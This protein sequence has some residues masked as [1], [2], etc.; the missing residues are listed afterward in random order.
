MR[1]KNRSPERPARITSAKFFQNR[2]A[3][4]LALDLRHRFRGLPN[5]RRSHRHGWRR[6]R[7][8]TSKREFLAIQPAQHPSVGALHRESQRVADGLDRRHYAMHARSAVH[9]FV[10]RLRNGFLCLGLLRRL[11]LSRRRN[12]VPKFAHD[13]CSLVINSNFEFV[14]LVP[15]ASHQCT[16]SRASPTSLSLSRPVPRI[17]AFTPAPHVFASPRP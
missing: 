15:S 11:V 14:S 17:R 4:N 10:T 9:H 5:G 13:S 1:Q 8:V 7:F 3:R 6:V 2:L 16:S 12:L